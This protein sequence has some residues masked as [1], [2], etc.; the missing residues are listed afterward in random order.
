MCVGSKHP[1]ACGNAARPEPVTAPLSAC[2]AL[3]SLAAGRTSATCFRDSFRFSTTTTQQFRKQNCEVLGIPLFLFAHGLSLPTPP[4]DCH[5]SQPAAELRSWLS[6]PV[7][8]RGKT[9]RKGRYAGKGLLA[10][11][12][13]NNL[14]IPMPHFHLWPTRTQDLPPPF[15]RRREHAQCQTEPRGQAGGSA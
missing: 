8:G 15:P 11:P 4:P 7:D 9:G 1:S 13:P 12:A 2:P 6:D 14:K 5:T 3:A 10:L